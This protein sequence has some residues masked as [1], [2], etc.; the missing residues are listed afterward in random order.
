M[1]LNELYNL[2][3]T[4]INSQIKKNGFSKTKNV[5]KNTFE[6]EMLEEFNAELDCLEGEALPIDYQFSDI[7][8]MYKKI[9]ERNIE[10]IGICDRR[11]AIVISIALNMLAYNCYAHDKDNYLKIRE[12]MFETE[13]FTKTC[14]TKINKLINYSNKKQKKLF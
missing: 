13:D 1:N 3:C 5:Y 2:I 4:N 12:I 14:P 10:R 7:V 11:S 9:F 8:E 6:N